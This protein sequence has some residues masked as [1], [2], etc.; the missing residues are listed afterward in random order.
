MNRILFILFLLGGGICLQAKDYTLQE[1]PMVHLEDRMRYV[2]NPDTILADSIVARMDS[3]LYA[4]EEKT[5]IQT[6]V[7]AGTGIEGGDCFDFAHRLGME[8]G[9]GGDGVRPTINSY[10]YG[11]A[12]ALQKIAEM[13]NNSSVAQKYKNKAENLK[14]NVMKKLWNESERFFETISVNGKSVSVRELIGYVPWYFN[15]PEDSEKYSVAFAQLLDKKGFLYLNFLILHQKSLFF[16]HNNKKKW[17]PEIGIA[18]FVW[19]N[20]LVRRTL[21][22]LFG[23]KDTIN[24]GIDVLFVFLLQKMVFLS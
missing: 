1:I 6:L 2:S 9:V 10:M 14:N 7:V 20:P 21:L 15:L 22:D 24:I 12:V 17:V 23:G 3:L 13:I 11:D 19:Q 18:V 5:G 8:K 4:L 16:C